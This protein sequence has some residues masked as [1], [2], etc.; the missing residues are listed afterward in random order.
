MYA[1]RG[2]FP[3]DDGSKTHQSTLGGP[4]P[5]PV[6]TAENPRAQ[7]ALWANDS[8]GLLCALQQFPNLVPLGVAQSGHLPV[9]V[10]LTVS[11]AA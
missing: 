11:L 1:E 5:F 2:K 7:K 6:G 4:F 9:P 10:R 8:D 3:G